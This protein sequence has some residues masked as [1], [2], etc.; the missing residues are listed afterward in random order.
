MSSADKDFKKSAHALIDRL[1]HNAG[2]GELA[3]RASARRDLEEQ[4]DGVVGQVAEEAFEEYERMQA[5]VERRSS[6][7]DREGW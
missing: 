2:W 4:D 1:P 5:E 7:A 3:D 6:R